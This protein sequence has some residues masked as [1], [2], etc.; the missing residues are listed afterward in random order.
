MREILRKS[1]FMEINVW[2]KK[3]GRN[4]DPR[5]ERGGPTRPD[6]LAAWAHSFCPSESR[7]VSFSTL[8]L[9]LDLK[10][11]NIYPLQ[12]SN[13]APSV[14][15]RSLFLVFP[16]CQGLAMSCSGSNLEG[17]NPP[18]EGVVNHYLKEQTMSRMSP[19]GGV[20][21]R[22]TLFLIRGLIIAE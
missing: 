17:E 12:Q 10:T 2:D 20:N 6:S 13:L 11:L 7:F 22:L 19:R 16:V 18:K 3:I 14:L 4:G 1:F 15:E 21:R 5:N 8:T 9:R